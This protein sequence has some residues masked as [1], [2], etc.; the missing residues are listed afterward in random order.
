MTRIHQLVDSP[1]HEASASSG[2]PWADNRAASDYE[3]HNIYLNDVSEDAS[4]SSI[5]D[6]FVTAAT[7]KTT[8]FI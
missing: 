8:T 6:Y 3:D 7:I 4:E 5:L 2:R 1:T